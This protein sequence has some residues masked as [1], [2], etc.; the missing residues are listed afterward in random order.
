MF[1]VRVNVNN[2]EIEYDRDCNAKPL[3]KCWDNGGKN[4]QNVWTICSKLW[5]ND[6]K[7]CKDK[8][9]EMIVQ[10]CGCW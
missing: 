1:V 8:S 6:N 9:V 2:N 3:L 10:L 7:W 4:L 5:E